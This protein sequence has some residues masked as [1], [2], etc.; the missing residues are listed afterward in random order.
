MRSMFWDPAGTWDP[1]GPAMVALVTVT[2]LIATAS[3]HHPISIALIWCNILRVD[4]LSVFYR[5]LIT[6]LL[7]LCRSVLLSDRLFFFV[8]LNARTSL[9]IPWCLACSYATCRRWAE[10]VGGTQSRIK[11]DVFFTHGWARRVWRGTFKA[12]ISE[13]VS[14]MVTSHFFT[15]PET[16]IFA[17]EN[18]PLEKEIP[19][20]NHHF[21]GLCWFQGV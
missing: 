1:H 15:L 4:C 18:R 7:H 14:F 11:D 20:G 8:L 9:A 19:I 6:L 5:F 21:Q 12:D 13:I 17:P 16:N 10:R 3:L 2:T